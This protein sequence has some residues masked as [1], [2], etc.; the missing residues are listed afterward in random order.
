M[1]KKNS[2]FLLEPFHGIPVTNAE[3]WLARIVSDYR[4]PH[5]AY[6]PQQA[7]KPYFQFH[8]DPDY[9]NIARVLNDISTTRIQLSLLDVLDI[10]HEDFKSK[11]HT[12]H[13]RKVER[14]RIHQDAA[15]LEKTLSDEEVASDIKEWGFDMFSPMYFVVGLLVTNDIT[16]KSS[17]NVGHRTKAD[18]DAAKAGS[19]AFGATNLDI[20]SAKIGAADSHEQGTEAKTRAS[21]KRVFA[22]EYRSFRRHMRQ[23]SGRIGR[24]RGYGPQGDRTFGPGDKADDDVEVHTELDP[25]PF[26]D[27]LEIDEEEERSINLDDV[28]TVAVDSAP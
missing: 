19:L 21:G 25:E 12:F 6:T 3:E 1:S 9:S 7:R 11:K 18:F 17:E 24:I 20:A 10:S 15:V 27:I 26:S 4:R 23:R 22:V 2:F 28:S 14:L 16:Y 5:A 8:S 13:S